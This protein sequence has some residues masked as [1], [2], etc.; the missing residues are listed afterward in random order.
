M[1][2]NVEANFNSTLGERHLPHLLLKT[3]NACFR[4]F[5]SLGATKPPHDLFI[6][7][8]GADSVATGV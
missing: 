5:G 6:L 3:P 8:N 4:I 2:E 1:V 7:G